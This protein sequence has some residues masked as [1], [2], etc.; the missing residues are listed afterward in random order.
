MKSGR[1]HM[2]KLAEDRKFTVPDGDSI[3]QVVSLRSSNQSH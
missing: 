2:K 1:K 3:M